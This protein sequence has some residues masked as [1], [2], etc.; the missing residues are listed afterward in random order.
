[1]RTSNSRAWALLVLAIILVP[2]TNIPRVWAPGE[3]YS[4]SVNP[5]RVQEADVPGDSLVL[6]VANAV[7]GTNYRF[8]WNVQ[9]P[10]GVG[11]NAF[12][13][14]TATMSSF[15]LSVLYPRDF[16]PGTS[17][18]YVGN[19]TVNVQQNLPVNVP[20]VATGQFLAGLTDSKSYQRTS[21]VA[22]RAQGYQASEGVTVNISHGGTSAPGYPKTL[23]AVTGSLSTLWQVPANASTGIWTVGL[24]GATTNKV[25]PDTQTFNV[26]PTNV[27]ISQFIVTASTL[28]RTLTE[29]FRFTSTYLSGIQVQTGQAKLR[30]LE[31]DGV[32]SHNVTA[33]YTPVLGT[34]RATYRPALSAQLGIW[35]ATISPNDFNDGYGNGGPLTTVAKGFTV[36]P[37][38][39]GVSVTVFNQTYGVGNLIPVY[40]TITT[41]DGT[42]FNAGTV[43][44]RLS[45]SGVQIK[46]PIA[47]S[48]VAGQNKW[49]GSYQVNA[50]DPSG[51]WVVNVTASD[52]YGN[53]GQQSSSAI[54]SVP[55][56]PSA[57]PSILDSIGFLLLAIILAIAAAL[58]GLGFFWSHRKATKKEIRIDMKLVDN[59]VQRIEEK[60]FFQRVKKQVENKEDTGGKDSKPSVS[61][62]QDASSPSN[63]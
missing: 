2:A 36:Q 13:S 5:S 30:I 33:T 59:E 46:S 6:N 57:R 35:V 31:A 12:N 3:T 55:P 15:T 21:Q 10:T 16:G 1:M 28:Q 19:Y 20:S 56:P 17:I 9:D 27:T 34:F 32:T 53:T 45:H 7:I 60:D 42:I 49:A 43:T 4:L 50:S 54:V 18:T 23:A 11:K 61:S 48:F 24:T 58:F 39:L 26:Y 14:T 29:E 38:S 25:I 41:P 63:T 8:T 52:S 40:A 47:L 22:I 62:K 51:I 44:A 37:A